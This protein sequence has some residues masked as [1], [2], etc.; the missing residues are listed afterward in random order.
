MAE[1]DMPDI[2][3]LKVLYGGENPNHQDIIKALGSH[4]DTRLYH[5]VS[6]IAN[7]DDMARLWLDLCIR[8]LIECHKFRFPPYFKIETKEHIFKAW[9]MFMGFYNPIQARWRE[10]LVFKIYCCIPGQ[11]LRGCACRECTCRIPSKE[12]R[13]F[14]H[15]AET[16]PH[17]FEDMI[18][19][20]EYAMDLALDLNHFSAKPASYVT[21]DY[22][23]FNMDKNKQVLHKLGIYKPEHQKIKYIRDRSL[24]VDNYGDIMVRNSLL[25]TKQADYESDTDTYSD[26][27][28]DE[29]NIWNMILCR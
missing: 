26:T 13:K 15:I 27:D 24:S 17:E 19:K 25:E 2:N 8:C 20:T 3:A 28:T 14:I 23:W 5:E 18:K 7:S 11:Q 1:S 9:D 6:E 29:S 21:E 10:E 16:K 22:P 12:L 4:P